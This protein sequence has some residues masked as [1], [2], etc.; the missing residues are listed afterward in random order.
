MDNRNRIQFARPD[1]D[2]LTSAFTAVDMH[3]HS[4]F[5][6]GACHVDQIV[7]RCKDLGIGIAVTDHNA[8]AGAVEV[9][10]IGGVLSIPGIEVTSAEGTHLLVYFDEIEDLNK[11]FHDAIR[12]FMGPETMSSTSLAMELI[13]DR[14]RN[15]PSLVVFPH[16]YSAAYTGIC[17]LQFSQ[18]RRELLLE[19]ADGVEVINAGNMKRWNLQSALL[20]FNLD[21][22]ITAGSD[23]HRIDELGGALVYAD[24]PAEPKAFLDA[25]RRKQNKV[26]GRESA[27]LKKVRSNGRKL[28]SNF[29]NYPDLMEK[30]IRYSYTLL[31]ATSR[32]LRQR[33]RD[34][35]NGRFNGTAG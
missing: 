7:E 35:L 31:N 4:R 21:K 32:K 24:C 34:H 16:P 14:A 5:S 20:G 2:V 8:V 3:F 13:V 9:A 19:A 10:R 11:F 26:I 25:V 28:R 6:D 33:V 29:K 22:V 15:Y 12:P 17:N 23:G 30:N 18:Q 1:L 27:I